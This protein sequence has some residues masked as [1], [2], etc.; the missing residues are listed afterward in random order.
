MAVP[1][2]QELKKRRS[3]REKLTRLRTMYG[4]SR[5]QDERT[6][7]LGK[8][9]RVSPGLSAETFLAPLRRS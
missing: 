8:A 9:A 6:R 5:T 7:I 2:S 3:R 4:A 1:R